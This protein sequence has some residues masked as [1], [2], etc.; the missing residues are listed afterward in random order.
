MEKVKVGGFK[1]I[2][3]HYKQ[4]N[5]RKKETIV[6]HSVPKFEFKYHNLSTEIY[7]AIEKELCLWSRS[8]YI[9]LLA[10]IM[11]LLSEY[12]N[13]DYPAKEYRH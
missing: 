9:R 1:C 12:D 3:V 11:D 6:N 4:G 8:K 5:F 2:H 7:V 13:S 10:I